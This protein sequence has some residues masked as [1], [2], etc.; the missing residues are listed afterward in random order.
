L[1]VFESLI[2]LRVVVHI[3]IFYKGMHKIMLLISTCLTTKTCFLLCKYIS[4]GELGEKENNIKIF[5]GLKL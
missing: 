1:D 5:K 4:L 2:D 3:A